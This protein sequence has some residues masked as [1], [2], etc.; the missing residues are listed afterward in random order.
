MRGVYIWISK[1][2]QYASII[3]E[4]VTHIPESIN[5][6]VELI[7]EGVYSGYWNVFWGHPCCHWDCIGV[8][9]VKSH[10]GTLNNIGNPSDNSLERKSHKNSF[11]YKVIFHLTNHFWILHRAR[12][13]DCYA[14]CKISEWFVY[15]ERSYVQMSFCGVQVSDGFPM[16]YCPGF[17]FGKHCN[18]MWPFGK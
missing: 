17:G 8:Y 9:F 4:I 7:L 15:D 6:Q 2:A 10:I 11:A 16:E 13:Y 12:K 14:L 18:Y 5:T 3:K 1:V